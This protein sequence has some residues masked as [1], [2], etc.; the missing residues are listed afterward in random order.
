MTGRMKAFKEKCR[1]NHKIFEEKKIEL[2][3][4]YRTRREQMELCASFLY[5]LADIL[6]EDYE[7][8]G[9][10]NRDQS[11][12]LIPKGTEKEV[13][14]Y[15]KPLFSFRVSDHWNWYSNVKKCRKLDYI[16]CN[17]LDIPEAKEREDERATEPIVGCQVAI[18]GTDGNYH[19]VF[20]EKYDR[21]TRSWSWIDSD[22]MDVCKVYGLAKEV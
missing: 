10:C 7:V 17:S 15:G 11:C 18:Q 8:I 19:H 16:Q 12:Y 21:K 13:T 3:G 9:S 5:K 6:K 2:G 22:P 1:Q 4:D 20:G 14:Y